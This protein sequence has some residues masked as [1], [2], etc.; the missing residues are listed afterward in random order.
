MNNREFLNYLENEFNSI[1]SLKY[2]TKEQKNVIG[3]IYDEFVKVLDR[4]NFTLYEPFNYSIN[5]DGDLLLF[6]RSEKR[7]TNIIINTDGFDTA[8]SY[9][10]VSNNEKCIL[11]FVY[12][13]EGTFEKL[14]YDF[15]NH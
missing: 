5:I 9:I 6:K 10:P 1:Q 8:F 12:E 15:L 2:L 11:Y 13:G 14:V 3:I 4:S 7:L